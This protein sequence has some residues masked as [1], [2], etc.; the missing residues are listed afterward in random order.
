MKKISKKNSK[1]D[2]LNL[3]II[4][5]DE[6]LTE[7]LV[8]IFTDEGYIINCYSDTSDILSLVNEFKPDVVLLD[9]MLPK[10]NGGELCS[11]I[12]QH[13][14]FN[15]IPVIIYSAFS[16]VLLS[17]GDYGCD[18]FLEKPFDITDLV[19]K[20]KKLAKNHKNVA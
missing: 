20:I 5:D 11:Q 3:L 7:I 1:S 8:Q 10:V 15:H 2:R 16:K 13:E 19:R 12:K 9:Y 4:E 14:K 6:S 18:I 17:L